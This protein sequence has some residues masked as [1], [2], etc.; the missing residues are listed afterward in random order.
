[1][2]KSWC[3][4]CLCLLLSGCGNATGSFEQGDKKLDKVFDSIED[5]IADQTF[6]MA[7]LQDQAMDKAQV[8]KNYHLDMTKIDDCMV[9]T[10]LLPAQ[11]SEVAIFKCDKQKDAMLRKGIHYRLQQLDAAWGALVP[12]AK[13]LLHDAKQGRLGAYY[14]FVLG[15]DSKKVVNYMQKMD[16]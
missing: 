8:E 1:M 4:L 15:S 7:L 13:Q 6:A 12:E 14:Y 5:H 11:L 10:S 2:K 3:L 9:K 16:A